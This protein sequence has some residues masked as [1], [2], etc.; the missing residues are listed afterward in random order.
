MIGRGAIVQRR[1]QDAKLAGALIARLIEQ[2]RDFGDDL[3]HRFGTGER[4][5]LCVRQCMFGITLEPVREGLQKIAIGANKQVARARGGNC[6]RKIGITPRRQRADLVAR[7][8][9]LRIVAPEGV[10]FGGAGGIIAVEPG[11]NRFG[12]GVEAGLEK[13]RYGRIGGRIFEIR[14]KIRKRNGAGKCRHLLG[15]G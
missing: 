7:G 13:S 11:I 10:R 8:V 9:E 14:L 3:P 4:G 5:G 1:E 6:S 15:K 12:C 2:R